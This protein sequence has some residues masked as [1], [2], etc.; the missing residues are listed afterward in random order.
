MQF[1]GDIII[2]HPELIPEL[3]HDSVALEWGYEADQPNEQQGELF[4]AA[5]IPFYVCPGTSSWNTVAGRTDNAIG[6][7]LNAA[8]N[9]LK[10]GASGFLNTDWGDNG[11]WQMLPISYLG[12]AVGAAYSWALDANRA[13]DAA[14]LVGRHAFRDAA[15]AM[16][17]VAFDMG[18]VYK[19][20]SLVPHNGSTLFWT[21]QSP[22]EKI[23]E[24]GLPAAEWDG[25]REAI[26]AAMAP[27]GQAKMGRPDAA[28]VIREYEYTARLLRHACRRGQL[29]SDH[30]D[31]SA[32][33]RELDADMCEIIEEYRS[34]WLARNRPGGLK[35]SVAL[36]ERA[37]KD[38]AQA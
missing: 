30:S 33:R 14:E 11:H 23:K 31:G 4:V 19:A 20:G 32:L 34:L 10:H 1:W 27:L 12:F 22:L 15:G 3:P 21:L 36:L 17:R 8:E 35:D 24:Y 5:G 25:W 37:R 13:L 16:G 6:N 18:N 9:G 38:Y 26:Q 7:L 28:L 29:A 2:Q